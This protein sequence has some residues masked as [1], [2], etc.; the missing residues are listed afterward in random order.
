[1]IAAYLLTS[2]LAFS[3]AIYMVEKPNRVKRIVGG[4][5][6]AIPPI[7]DPTVYIYKKDHDA[8]VVGKRESPDSYYAFRGIRYAEPPV[9]PLRFQVFLFIY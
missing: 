9:G 6:A 5:D 7:D 2:A 1:M 4:D 3:H 8:R